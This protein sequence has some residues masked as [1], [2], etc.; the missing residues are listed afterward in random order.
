MNFKF[1]IHPCPFS[2]W[3]GSSP[4]CGRRRRCWTYPSQ[5]SSPASS[6]PTTSPS[7]SGTIL[8]LQSFCIWCDGSVWT[9]NMEILQSSFNFFL[10]ITT[11][12]CNKTFE[13][14][15]R[16]SNG[17]LHPNIKD[18]AQF[19]QLNDNQRRVVVGVTRSCLEDN[20][21]KISLVQG[22]GINYE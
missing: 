9:L 17:A 19:R 20:E 18:L 21:S 7:L 14:I 4:T 5:S 13:S 3:R 1:N 12:N 8:L 6:T 2:S 16:A 22:R 11:K 10:H 15:S